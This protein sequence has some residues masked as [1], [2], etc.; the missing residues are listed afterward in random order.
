MVN[1]ASGGALVNKTQAHA[2]DLFNIM[3]R[4]IQ[5]FGNRKT[6][7]RKVNELSL[8]LSVET[9]L[10][11]IIAMLNKLITGVVQKEWCVVFAV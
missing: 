6:Q 1:A 10:S 9:Q 7:F 11:Q 8:G 3:V 2:R 5:Q 4:N